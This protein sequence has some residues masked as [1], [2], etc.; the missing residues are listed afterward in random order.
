MRLRKAAMDQIEAMA[1]P[2]L[3]IWAKLRDQVDAILE[4]NGAVGAMVARGDDAANLV[5]QNI[6]TGVALNVTY[7]FNNLDSPPGNRSKGESYLVNVLPTQ[8]ISMPEPMNASICSG[9]CEVI[10]GF[11]SIGGRRYQSTV[12]M[13]NHVLT[14]FQLKIVNS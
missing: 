2:C 1:K 4:M 12:T 5:V 3:T 6:G 11:E 7:R 9:N 13:N 8:K 10:F 14:A